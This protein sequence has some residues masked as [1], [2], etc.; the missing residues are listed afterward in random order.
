MNAVKRCARSARLAI[1][2]VCLGTVILAFMAT[3]RSLAASGTINEGGCLNC[4]G[5]EE[6]SCF[7]GDW[8]EYWGTC[9]D[10]SRPSR[11]CYVS[12]V[13]GTY[14]RKFSSASVGQ[15]CWGWYSDP[16]TCS[17]TYYCWCSGTWTLNFDVWSQIWEVIYG[18][19]CYLT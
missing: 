4:Y 1:G 14:G 11:A 10:G 17:V 15:E 5:W 7:E 8:E 6:A 16:V 13:T 2:I 18:P 12:S 9:P 3:G 19:N